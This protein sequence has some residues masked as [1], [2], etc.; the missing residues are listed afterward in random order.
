MNNT[1]RQERGKGKHAA[2]KKANGS[3]QINLIAEKNRR[4]KNLISTTWA[5]HVYFLFLKTKNKKQKQKQ[6]QQKQQNNKTTK[7]ET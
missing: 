7:Q 2:E 5:H 1:C 4:N 3:A 6:K